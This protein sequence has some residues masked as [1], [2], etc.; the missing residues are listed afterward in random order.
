[1]II[2]ANLLEGINIGIVI[3]IIIALPFTW[4]VGV[5]TYKRGIKD[6]KDA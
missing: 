4:L 3:G 1:M 6:G 2:D 5:A